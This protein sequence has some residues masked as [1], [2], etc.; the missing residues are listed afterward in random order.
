MG[1]LEILP[2]KGHRDSRRAYYTD[3]QLLVSYMVDLLDP[4][5]DDV[6]L[7]PCAG[8]G[9]FVDELIRRNAGLRIQ[10]Y[11]LLAPETSALRARYRSLPSVKIAQAD[12][13]LD[14]KARSPFARYDKIIAN[15]PYGAWQEPARRSLLKQRF[16]DLYVKE[17]SVLF[18]AHAISMLKANGRAVF[19]L[20]ETFL[21]THTQRALRKRLLE[22]CTIESIDIFPSSLFPGVNFGYAR[23][24][25]ISIRAQNLKS[26]HY[27]SVRHSNSLHE[28]VTRLGDQHEVVQESIS[29]HPELAFPLHA[30]TAEAETLTAQSTT[31]GELADCVTGFYSGDDRQFL[32]RSMAN[33]KYARRYPALDVDLVSKDVRCPINGLSGKKHFVPIL[34]GGGYPYLKPELWYIDW[35]E[36]AVSHYKT[37]KKARFQNSLYYF[38]AGIGFPMVSSSRATASVIQPHQ[39]FDQSVVGVFPKSDELFGFILALLN[40]TTGWR[41]LRQI[42]PSTNNS[43]K[44]LRRLPVA[45]PTKDDLSWFNEVTQAYVLRLAQGYK[46]DPD[47]ESTLDK[48][49]SRIFSEA[50]VRLDATTN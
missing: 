48:E 43:A 33:T 15:P 18:L 24:C 1:L 6:C 46:A 39:L 20:P 22:S 38:R 9:H 4:Q 42:N 12:Y 19:I 5:N 31:L 47:L 16:P 3:D 41:L 44:Y 28:L 50:S 27:F 8:E 2:R 35:S 32:R 30:P 17:S 36:A 25:I 34:K 21:F 29:A 14:D 10:A 40:S 13:L 26:G 45:V 11:E 7:E 37:D 23:L 49:I